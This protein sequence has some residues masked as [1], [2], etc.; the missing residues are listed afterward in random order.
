LLLLGLGS[1]RPGETYKELN[2]KKVRKRKMKKKQRE[3]EVALLPA[4][5]LKCL[6]KTMLFTSGV[7][8]TPDYLV[9]GIADG[10]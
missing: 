6:K 9:F 2:F 8:P 10:D 7:W 5:D 3:K 4:V 1:A